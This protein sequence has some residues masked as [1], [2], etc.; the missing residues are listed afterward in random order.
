MFQC[1]GLGSVEDGGCGEDWY[2]PGCIVGLGRD[3]YEKAQQQKA[4][5]PDGGITRDSKDAATEKS[6][7]VEVQNNP[8]T[9]KTPGAP[10]DPTPNA[11]TANGDGSDD[12]E[13][14]LPPGFPDED[15]FDTFICYKCVAANPWIKR[16]AGTEGF[17]PAIYKK[18]AMETRGESDKA[19]DKTPE[20]ASVA[21]SNNNNPALPDRSA[22]QNASS[23][24]RK[25][26]DDDLR[27]TTTEE[28]P[29]SKK[30]KAEEPSSSSI[31]PSPP[32]CIYKTLPPAPTGTFSL[33]LTGNFRA[34]LCHCPE[35]FPHLAP[36]Q[37]LLEEE[38]IY[39]PPLS[40]SGG[41]DDRAS[42]APSVSNSLLERG[43]RALA[44]IDRVRAIEGAMAYNKLKE[45]VKDFLKPFAETGRL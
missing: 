4:T 14:P 17:L 19:Q 29:I 37:S 32:P 26:D 1:L 36:H 9:R 28:E 22:H 18:D 38:P 35:H 12:E 33:F 25:P 45:K 8:A 2:H 34:H 6:D 31:N 30:L 5:K 13:T 40:S 23:K 15:E 24:K 20:T 27:T 42:N 10:A 7:Q 43:E 11:A 41:G 39:E 44:N 3:W 21:P 16:Y